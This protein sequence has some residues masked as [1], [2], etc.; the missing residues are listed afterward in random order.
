MDCNNIITDMKEDNAALISHL[1]L[2]LFSC[3]YVCFFRIQYLNLVIIVSEP[4][5]SSI[6]SEIIKAANASP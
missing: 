4:F 1:P 2:L 5:D 3:V 6:A